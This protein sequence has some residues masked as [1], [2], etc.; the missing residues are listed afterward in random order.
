MIAMTEA[1]ARDLVARNAEKLREA[2]NA[3]LAYETDAITQHKLA[4]VCAEC[5]WC[6]REYGEAAR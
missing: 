2:V 1:C 5:N 3:V 4:E 6:E